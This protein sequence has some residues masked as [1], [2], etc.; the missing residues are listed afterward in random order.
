MNTNAPIVPLPDSR[1]RVRIDAGSRAPWSMTWV[2]AESRATTRRTSTRRSTRVRQAARRRKIV[3][4][5]PPSRPGNSNPRHAESKKEPR[6]PEP[7]KSPLSKKITSPSPPCA[8]A[9]RRPTGRGSRS[10]CHASIAKGTK[11]IT[12]C[13]AC[14]STEGGGATDDRGESK[15]GRAC[16]CHPDGALAFRPT[17]S[18]N[19]IKPTKTP[20]SALKVG[21][22]AGRRRCAPGQ[23]RGPPR[24]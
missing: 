18:H 14:P 7:T 4:A 17:A 9:P 1:A 13:G 6:M 2:S 3:V 16:V 5:S 8:A 23:R 21:C 12:T 22:A 20:K 19:E 11:Y 24:A 10:A 15:D